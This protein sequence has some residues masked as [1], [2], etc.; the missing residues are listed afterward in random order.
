M[1]AK[2]VMVQGTGSSVGKSL[3]T[4]ALC[5]IFTQDGYRVLPF[6]SQNM[7]NNAAVTQDG[8]ELSRA[9]AEQA[10]ACRVEPSVLMNPVLLKPTTDIGAQVVVLGKAIGTMDAVAYDRFKLQ[11]KQVILQSLKTLGDQADIL[12]IEGAGSPAEI[13]LKDRDLANMWIAEQA[14]ASVLLVG[15]IDKGGV[16]A[17]F[18]GTMELLDGDERALV[19]GF[20]INKFRG[21]ASLLA[22][23]IEWLERR[24]SRPVLGTVPYLHN[25][26]VAEEDA[27]TQRHHR[28][29]DGNGC[30]RIEVVSLSRISNVSDF[31][32]LRREPDVELRFIDR[33][34][35][36]ALPDCLILPGSKSTIA[37][38]QAIR[39]RGMETYVRRCVE[40]GTEVVGIC[41]GFQMLG[42]AIRDP[43]HVEARVSEAEGL[44]WLPTVTVFH[45]D[46]LTAQARGIHLESRLPVEGYEIHCGRMYPAPEAEPVVKIIERGGVPAEELD[47]TQAR[48][49]QVWGTHLHGL[50]DAAAFRAWWLHRFRQRKGLSA[51]STDVAQ[52]RHDPYDRLADAVR[53]H[54]DMPRL[55]QI[56]FGR[57]A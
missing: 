46:K 29:A 25:V 50:F 24:C 31:D 52:D 43:E 17:Q 37:D 35:E 54:L 49:G 8:G 26:D 16:F 33:P 21:D 55:Y 12:V 34:S 36:D 5:R 1:L 53:P 41:G 23:G 11:I 48:N 27:V 47:G 56:V 2:A 10:R 44:G 13:N 7:S 28:A 15:D 32:A 19:K 30:V 38:L 40:A 39:E 9:Q 57:G 14:K 51:R 20:L 42:Q 4:A 22:P 45:R 18:V 6:K 3:L